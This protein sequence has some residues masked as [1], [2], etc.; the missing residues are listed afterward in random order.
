MGALRLRCFSSLALE[1]GVRHVYLFCCHFEPLYTHILHAAPL[2]PVSSPWVGG[3]GR[4]PRPPSPT[5]VWEEQ[6]GLLLPGSW[7]CTPGLAL[8]CSPARGA[9]THGPHPRGTD[10]ESQCSLNGHSS[11]LI[12][13]RDLVHSRTC[14]VPKPVPAP[15]SGHG[16]AARKRQ[17]SQPKRVFCVLL[18][19]LP[20]AGGWSGGRWTMLARDEPN[21]QSSTEC[22]VTTE[23]GQ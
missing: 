21:R 17:G 22:A 7:P 9:S 18:W 16:D 8:H 2:H 13:L 10:T 15:W 12:R 14:S 11:R 19:A 4:S 20:W 6:A 3:G 1:R 23:P 5:T